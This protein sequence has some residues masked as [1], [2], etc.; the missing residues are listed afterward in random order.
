[1]AVPGALPLLDSLSTHFESALSQFPESKQF[2]EMMPGLNFGS[3]EATEDDHP[4]PGLLLAS[5]G[6]KPKHPVIIV[7]GALGGWTCAAVSCS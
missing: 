2:W 5:K 1:M 7:P 3:G 4:R 6:Y